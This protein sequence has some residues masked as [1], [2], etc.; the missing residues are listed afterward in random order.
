LSRATRRDRHGDVVILIT[1]VTPDALSVT[2]RIIVMRRGREAAKGM[3]TR[4]NTEELAQHT[5][6][7]WKDDA[8]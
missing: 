7:E 5:A 2:D 1:R 8:A 6:R 3:T 4:A